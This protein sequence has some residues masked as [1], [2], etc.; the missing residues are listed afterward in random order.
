MNL[1]KF[2]V[3]FFSVINFVMASSDALDHKHVLFTEVLQE[4]TV[5]KE[6]VV[7]IDY[8]RLSKNSKKLEMYLNQL[9]S[10]SYPDLLK[11]ERSKRL[12]FWINAYNAY[13]VK[14][15]ID[16]Y[17]IDSI[18]DIKSGDFWNRLF[19]KGPWK[20]KFIPLFGMKMSLDDIEHG[21]L[22]PKYDEPRIHFAINCA[23]ISC[24][25]LRREAYTFDRIEEQ[26]EDSTLKFLNDIKNNQVKGDEIEISKVFKWFKEDFEKKYGSVEN[27]IQQ[28]LKLPNKKYDLDYKS[29]N[30]DLNDTKVLK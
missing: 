10:I 27:F 17:P 14:L 13:T 20:L 12:A 19:R 4:Y 30:W 22:R 7:L 29:Y 15:V 25:P 3:V 2:V 23:S 26:L 16:K 6:N 18:K 11:L 1:Y 24:P 5:Q 21:V 8:E 9:E 28:K